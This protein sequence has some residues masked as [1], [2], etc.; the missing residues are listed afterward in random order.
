MPVLDNF[1]ILACTHVALRRP[2]AHWSDPSVVRRGRDY[3]VVFSSIETV[4]SLQILHSTDLVNWDV[5]G[6]VSRHWFNATVD[7]RP[8]QKRQ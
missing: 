7:G 8:L 6:S 3:Y 5:A 4:P 2:N 1:L